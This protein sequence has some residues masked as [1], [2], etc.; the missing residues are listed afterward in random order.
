MSVWVE[1]TDA[2]VYIREEGGGGRGECVFRRSL[3]VYLM[4]AWDDDKDDQSSRLRSLNLRFVYFVL[5]L[6]NKAKTN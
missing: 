3:P 4:L 1:I 6:I 2:P 5:L